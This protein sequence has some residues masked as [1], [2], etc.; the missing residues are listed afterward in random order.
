MKHGIRPAVQKR[1]T[2]FDPRPCGEDRA[3]PDAR[4]VGVSASSPVGKVNSTWQLA[5][6]LRRMPVRRTRHIKAAHCGG[7]ARWRPLRL[8]L[9]DRVVIAIARPAGAWRCNCRRRYRDDQYAGSARCGQFIHDG[10]RVELR[11]VI[12]PTRQETLQ[13]TQL[14]VIRIHAVAGCCFSGRWIGSCSG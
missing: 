5:T 11:K 9:P 4:C 12:W 10:S 2:V 1:R 6:Q 13:T 7:C 8:L 14:T 3:V